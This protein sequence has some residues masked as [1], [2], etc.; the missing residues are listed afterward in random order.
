MNESGPPSRVKP[1]TRSVEITPPIRSFASSTT[2]SIGLRKE[3]VQLVDPVSRGQAGE[4]PAD[5]DHAVEFSGGRG[6]LDQVH[7]LLQ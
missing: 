3:A 7:S 6:T 2:T 5:H 4:P 1:S